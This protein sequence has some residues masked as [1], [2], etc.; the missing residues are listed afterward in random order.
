M[1]RY[2]HT[3]I[4]KWQT[5]G[6]FD[7]DGNYQSGTAVE[8]SIEGRADVAGSGSLVSMEDGSQVSYGWDFFTQVQEFEAPFNAQAE[9]KEGDVTLWKGTVK[10][11]ANQQKH[12]R[13]WL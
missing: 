2:P 9:L 7:D 6:G 1:V 12:T 13:I 10:R 8:K 11:F 4:V 3:L 5:E